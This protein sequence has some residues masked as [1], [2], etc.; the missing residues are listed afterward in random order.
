MK[1]TAGTFF[2][3]FLCPLYPPRC[4]WSHAIAHTRFHR[5]KEYMPKHW[6]VTHPM[7]EGLHNPYVLTAVGSFLPRVHAVAGRQILLLCPR[8]I[9][10]IPCGH[11]KCYLYIW[12]GFLLGVFQWPHLSVDEQ[13]SHEC[14]D[15]NRP[16]HLCLQILKLPVFCLIF[17]PSMALNT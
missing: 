14:R 10:H 13:S 7:N 3:S 9:S 11:R 4:L 5:H 8:S 2:D 6:R 17:L 15:L 1:H 16:H 12:T